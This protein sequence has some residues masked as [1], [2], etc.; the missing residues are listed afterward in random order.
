MIKMMKPDYSHLS[1][2]DLIL[3]LKNGETETEN[4]LL[5]KYKALVRKNARV[6]YLDGGDKEDLLQEGMLG[7]FKAIRSFEP[8]RGASFFTYANQCIMNQMFSAVSSAKRKKHSILN[9]SVPLSEIDDASQEAAFIYADGPEAFILEQEAEAQ[10]RS[11]IE[12]ALS[13]MENKVLAQ[14]LQGMNYREIAEQ[15]GKSEKSIDNA[16]QRIRRKVKEVR[17]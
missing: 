12:K 17:N 15:T 5:E 10:L 8:D 6:L 13:P 16:L 1:D 3:R 11:R 2:E 4:Y 14:Y 9:E 7:L